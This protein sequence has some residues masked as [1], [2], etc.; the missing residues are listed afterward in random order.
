MTL[1]VARDFVFTT[2]LYAMDSMIV[3]STRLT[4]F[5]VVGYLFSLV[6]SLFM[7]YVPYK[8]FFLH[9]LCFFFSRP[10]SVF[11]NLL[12]FFSHK[13]LAQNLLVY[14]DYCTRP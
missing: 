11:H 5:D 14:Y 13:L 1:T 7:F 6:F 10:F 2:V 9:I 3:S 12:S 8:P 4:K